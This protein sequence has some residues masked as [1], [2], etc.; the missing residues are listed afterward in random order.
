MACEEICVRNDSI[1]VLEKTETFG[2]GTICVGTFAESDR[3]WLKGLSVPT[4]TQLDM[5]ELWETRDPVDKTDLRDEETERVAEIA[6]DVLA[7]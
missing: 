3:P 5:G 2:G 1:F 4:E 7:C 6:E